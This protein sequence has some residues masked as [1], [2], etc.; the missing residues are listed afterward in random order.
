MTTNLNDLLSSRIAAA[1]ALDTAE[2]EHRQFDLYSTSI[3]LA[4]ATEASRKASCD[5]DAAYASALADE[6]SKVVAA[7]AHIPLLYG[8]SHQIPA[9]D[10]LLSDSIASR[11]SC[12]GLDHWDRVTA[13]LSQGVIR[14]GQTGG[15]IVDSDDELIE[16]RARLGRTCI[17]D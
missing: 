12:G 2:K 7:R 6:E 13:T 5:Y 8:M 1:N 17:K 10:V 11:N 3:K 16:V 14:V 9:K 15:C 4:L